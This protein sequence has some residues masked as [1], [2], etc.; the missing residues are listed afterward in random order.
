MHYTESMGCS[1]YNIRLGAGRHRFELKT[2]EN[3]GL[4]PLSTMEAHWVQQLCL[5]SD[6]RSQDSCNENKMEWGIMLG[7][8]WGDKQ[9][10]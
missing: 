6:L 9:G 8:H 2:L 4:N 3:T 5:S 7:L 1:G 10:Y